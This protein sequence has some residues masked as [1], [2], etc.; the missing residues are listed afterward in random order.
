VGLACA[1]LLAVV[2]PA[3]AAADGDDFPPSVDATA[4]AEILAWISDTLSAR[5]VAPEVARIM[6]NEILERAA[7]GAYD[8][9]DDAGVF[10]HE[11][12]RNLRAASNDKHVGLWPERLEDVNDEDT[13]YTPADP[14]Y[15]EHMRRTN[16]GFK[17]LE[18]LPGNVGYVR[19]DEFA[20]PALGG[21]TAVAVMNAVGSVDALIVDLRWN[22][23]GSGLV[24]F[25]SG[26]FFD[27]STR[28]ND[29]WERASGE[30]SQG[31]TPEYLPGPTL[32][33]V[34]LFVLVS[35]QTF[36][37]AED[38]AYGLQQAGRATVVGARSKGGGHPVEIARMIRHDMAVAMMIP[39]AKSVHR[40]T[41]TSWDA[42]GVAPDIDVAAE[43]ALEVAYHAAANA[44]LE[45]AS[46]DGARYRVEWAR[47]E[48][49]AGLNPVSLTR[50]QLNDYAG[51]YETR[52]FAVGD[53][54]V[55]LYQRDA[56]SAFPLVPMGND[57]FRFEGYDEVRFQFGRGHSGTVDRV[58]TLAADGGRSVR[59]RSDGPGP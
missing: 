51:S 44:L 28:L 40:V 47:Q 38:F 58:I 14:E 26:Y 41:G 22:G 21:P 53:E 46:D 36:S 33:H 5:Y 32:S 13:D 39:N 10:L 7:A 6:A 45:Q 54:D 23:G 37:A 43:R 4:R 17:K 12:E 52:S 31:W 29:V 9:L 24:N 19:I 27:E 16:Y 20:H 48:F 2:G 11:V 1:A 3:A 42:V 25:I 50:A 15:V 8:G 57:L 35:G 49:R 56:D 34:P 18:I 30:T 55:L 59:R